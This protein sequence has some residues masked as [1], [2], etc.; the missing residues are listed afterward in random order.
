M[1]LSSPSQ[2]EVFALQQGLSLHR[3]LARVNPAA[4]ASYVLRDEET[5]RA[6][7]M[8][9]V[10]EEWHELA[11][12]YKNLILWGHP[13]SG[14]SS[15]MSVARVLYELGKN[16]N[17]RVLIVSATHMLSERLAATIARYI[18]GRYGPELHQVFPGLRKGASAWSGTQLVVRRTTSAKDPSVWVCGVESQGVTG[19]RVDL[20]VLDDILTQINTYSAAQRERVFNWVMGTLIDRMSAKGRILA[21]GNTWHPDDTYHRLATREGWVSKRYPVRYSNGVLAWPERWPATR[22]AE[23]EATL[24]PHEFARKFLCEARDDSTARFRKDWIHQCA[25]RGDTGDP[26][27]WRLRKFINTVPAGCKTFTG[28]DLS[29]GKA[30]GDLTCIFTILVYPNG[31]REVL[32]IQAGRWQ[33]PEIVKRIEK[34]HE[35]FASI[36]TVEGSG[37]QELLNQM[38]R[39]QT[40]VPVKSYFTGAETFSD[41]NHGIE[42]MAVEMANSKWIIPSARQGSYFASEVREWIKALLYYDPASHPGDR[43]MASHFAVEGSRIRK[44]KGGY[45][46]LDT[47]TR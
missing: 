38:L 13:E 12:K 5:K 14:R 9:P 2:L 47:L 28:V 20:L 22:I 37:Q 21:L 24:L 16:P 7:L 31:D 30:H 23:M 46:R 29:T 27:S 44:P 32:N 3:Q 41:P 40:G 33:A 6:I 10:Q 35:A 18:E 15:Q 19:A 42:T 43:L 4:F 11:S 39:A 8:H 25:L 1:T 17:L 36:V 26:N 45:G 34:E